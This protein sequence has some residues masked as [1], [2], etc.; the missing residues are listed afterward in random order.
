M[1]S[2]TD[3]FLSLFSEGIG[4]EGVKTNKEKKEEDVFF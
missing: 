2:G 4:S 1:G 3:F